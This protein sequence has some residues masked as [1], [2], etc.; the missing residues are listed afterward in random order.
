MKFLI[1]DETDGWYDSLIIHLN[2]DENLECI[3]NDISKQ[4]IFVHEYMHFLQDV[5]TVFGWITLRQ[6]FSYVQHFYNDKKKY[7]LPYKVNSKEYKFHTNEELNK[8]YD[9]FYEKKDYNKKPKIDVQIDIEEIKP[10]NRLLLKSK[11]KNLKKYNVIISREQMFAKWKFGATAIQ[12]QMCH[13]FENHLKGIKSENTFYLPYDLPKVVAMKLF[14]I[15]AEDDILIFSLCDA[16]LMFYHP[17]ETYIHILKKMAN[18]NFSYSN[19]KQIYDYVKDNCDYEENDLIDLN[20]K[21]LEEQV[22]IVCNFS[23]IEEERDWLRN[24]IKKY[25]EK[26]EINPSFLAELLTRDPQKSLEGFIELIS[27]DNSPII[28]NTKNEFAMLNQDDTLE[29]ED[30]VFHWVY[31]DYMYKY[32]HDSDG[33]ICAYADICTEFMN[34]PYSMEPYRKSVKEKPYCQFQQ[35]F[36]SFGG[37]KKQKK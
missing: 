20:Y 18:C 16:C 9:A 32:I 30:S 7:Q 29:K 26:R 23:G 19:I 6:K 33:D 24:I 17:A 22:D 14:P 12:E 4:V 27:K 10:V 31:W 28:C 21:E 2:T 34:C 3:K 11:F 15:V 1:S 8:F 37:Y 35:Y 13:I 25:K 36:L 5:S